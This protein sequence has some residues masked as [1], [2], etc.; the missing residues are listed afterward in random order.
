[1]TTH[2]RRLVLIWGSVL[3]LLLLISA[4][5]Q[6]RVTQHRIFNQETPSRDPILNIAQFVKW[7]VL[8]TLPLYVVFLLLFVPVFRSRKAL[9]AAIVLLLVLLTAAWLMTR[10]SVADES[11]SSRPAPTPMEMESTMEPAPE[12]SPTGETT[13]SPGVPQWVP[14]LVSFIAVSTI[15]VAVAFLLWWFWPRLK[16]A[17]P[18]LELSREAEHALG[19]LE[20]GEALRNVVVRC[21]VEMGRVI[22]ETRGIRRLKAMTPREFEQ[23][24]AQLDLPRSPIHGL[25]RLFERVRYGTDEP[26]PVSAN[27]ARECLTAIVNAC[28]ESA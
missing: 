24:L 1:M 28:R 6:L 16:K 19:A 13:S 12:A 8:L 7:L 11:V 5:P 2:K 14:L 22:D 10:F 20:K 27:Q 23:Q 26:D 3:L 15:L 9:I 18:L 4:F 21:Y 17:S 25:T